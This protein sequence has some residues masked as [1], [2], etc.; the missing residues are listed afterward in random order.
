MKWLY[1]GIGLMAAF[2]LMLVVL[3]TSAEAVVYFQEDYFEKEYQKYG[4]L[5][6]VHM[7]MDDLLY[8][9]DEMLEYLRNE[10]EDLVV[11][12]TVDGKVREFFNEKEKRH[13]ADVQE[14]FVGA[15]R[16]RLAGVGL[17]VVL[18]AVLLL[19][20]QGRLLFQTMQWGIGLFVAAGGVLALLLSM[21]FKRYFIWFHLLFFDNEDW[22]LN[23][24]TDR[25][26]NIVP[27]GFFRDTAFFITGVFLAASLA[28]WF[29][30]GFLKRAQN[31]G[32]L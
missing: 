29:L 3:I 30:A 26:I 17:A 7:E 16:L 13:M 31:R 27:E 19:K 21:N 15:Q 11:K 4:V 22:L 2:C 9:T 28:I 5:G 8:V 23:P 1:G 32:M 25:L 10:R 18:S 12:A 14:L 6:Q 20:R 24:K